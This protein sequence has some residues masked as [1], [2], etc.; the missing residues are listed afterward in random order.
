M[1][2]KAF[3]VITGASRGLG[4]SIAVALARRVAPDS[5]FLL[6]SRSL[7]GLNE[8]KMLVQQH[9]SQVE[10]AV[11]ST[12]FGKPDVK[13]YETAINDA[14]G[15]KDFESA[16]IVH[17]AGSLGNNGNM[18]ADQTDLPELQAYFAT[19]LHST[20]ILNSVFLKTSADVK[21]RTVVQISS[22]AGIM[23]IESWSLYCTGKAARDMFFKVKGHLVRFHIISVHVQ[24]KQTSDYVQQR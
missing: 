21:I 13:E 10:V 23:P 8:T 7:P 16:M 2:K 22:L 9:N 11:H 12:D 6:M 17:N 20:M 24:G 3:I 1:D 15:K 4:R 18:A 14:F 19:N 5:T